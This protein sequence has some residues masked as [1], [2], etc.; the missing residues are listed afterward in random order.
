MAD[1]KRFA[2]QLDYLVPL[3]Q[4]LAELPRGH[5]E[6][7]QVLPLFE[8]TYSHRIPAEHRAPAYNG[9]P[10]WHGHVGWC[11]ISMG[12]DHWCI[13]FDTA[14]KLSQGMAWGPGGFNRD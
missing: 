12:T 9:K 5:A 6:R 7:N 11:R 14:Q 1:D 13:C 8:R 3:L 10:V 4:L 2:G